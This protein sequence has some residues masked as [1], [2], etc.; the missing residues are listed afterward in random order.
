MRTV[1]PERGQTIW[2]VCLQHMGSVEPV[3]DLLALN[4]AIRP[5]A[6]FDYAVGEAPPDILLPDKPTKPLTVAYYATNSIVPIGKINDVN[7]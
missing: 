1:N 4:P 7:L 2:D 6:V 3:F 5:D